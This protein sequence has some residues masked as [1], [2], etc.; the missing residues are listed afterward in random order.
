MLKGIDISNWQAGI[1][2][3]KLPIDFCICK[4]TEGTGFV[5][6][7]CDGFVQDCISNGI[8]WGFYHFA[9]NSEP[10]AEADYFIEN[11]LNYF[12]HGIPVLDWETGQSVQWVNTF[13]N[14]VHERTGVWPWVYANPWLFNQ[15]GVEPNCMRWIAWYPDVVRPTLDYDPGN[16]P[17][18]DGLVGCWQYASD[19]YVPGYDGYLD[20]NVFFGDIASW[21][22]YVGI[23]G[24]DAE[25]SGTDV[26]END[27]YKVTIERK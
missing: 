10:V 7:Y 25:T 13:V 11:T 18:T 9:G 8:L 21:N 26:L 12:G 6:V 5:D 22:A 1:V 17:E 27:K 2:P 14:R 15:G 23:D 4:A 16:V 3:S 20:V 24:E 19:G